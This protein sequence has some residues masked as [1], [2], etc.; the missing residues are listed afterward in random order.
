MT[1][2]ARLERAGTGLA[3]ADGGWYILN[4]ARMRWRGFP[5]GGAYTTFESGPEPSDRLGIGVHILWPGDRPGYYHAEEDLEGFLVLSGECVAV[6][7][8]E[9]QWMG[10][11]DYLHSPPGTAHITVGAGSGPCAILMY[12][13]RTPGGGIRYLPEAAAARHGAAVERE[14]DS[15]REVYADRPPIEDLPPCWPPAPAW[16][17]PEPP[18]GDARD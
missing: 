10:P 9:E 16:P 1:E 8:G 7:E 12:G 18:G 3:P 14:S 4:L 17:A 15:P 13:T 6:V 5:G 11:W 2:R